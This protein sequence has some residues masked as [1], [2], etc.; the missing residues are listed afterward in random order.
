MPERRVS[1]RVKISSY[2]DDLSPYVRER[3]SLFDGALHISE[4]LRGDISI[5]YLIDDLKR[6]GIFKYEFHK[7]SD[8]SETYAKHI[9]RI[10]ENNNEI[11]KIAIDLIARAHKL[12][13]SDIH[14]ADN[15]SYTR[16]KLRILGRLCEDTQLE[17]ST[18]RRL[19]RCIHDYMGSSTESSTFSETER[20]DGRIVSRKFLPEKVH[21]VRLHTE[22]IE[23]AQAENGTGTFMALRLLYDS[24]KAVGSLSNRLSALG[25]DKSHIETINHLM[26]RTGLTIISGPTGHGKSTV[27]KHIIEAMTYL[28]PEKAYHSVEDPPEFPM[29]GVHQIKVST[30]QDSSGNAKRSFAYTNA[31]AGA[32]R[33]D[34][35]VIIIGEIRYAEAAVAAIDAA[36]TGHAVWS[37]LHANDAFGIVT[38]IESLLRSMN[39]RDPLDAFCDPNVLAGIEYQRLIAKLCPHCK[40][41]F[42]DLNKEQQNIAMPKDVMSALSYVLEYDEIYGGTDKDNKECNGIF[43][44]GLGCEKCQQRGLIGQTVVAEVIALDQ[45]ILEMLRRGKMV[46]AYRCWKDT[47]GMTYIEHA[48]EYIRMGILDPVIATSRLGVPLNFN[49]FASS[50]KGK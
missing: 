39:F 48:L 16:I 28:W 18:G 24:T 21:S 31:L 47:G 42:K 20:N 13:A 37:T 15:G 49:K 5:T 35:D 9:T 19:I 45:E 4:D 6:H 34:P 2:F 8:F 7:Q 23:V 33:S 14:I 17:A 25:F 40:R 44:R 50:D 1:D 11:E 32:M 30:K 46:D 26:Q 41:L 22:P 29:S 38:R 27:L 43:V 10:V 3:L 36:L 12:G